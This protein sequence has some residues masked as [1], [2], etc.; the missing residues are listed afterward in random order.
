MVS[1]I[2]VDAVFHPLVY[3]STGDYY[4]RDAERRR[5]ARTQHRLFEV[6]LDSWFQPRK[7]AALPRRVSQ[8]LRALGRDF[9][10]ICSLLDETLSLGTL[11]AIDSPSGNWR[12]AFRYLSTLQSVFLN[13][14][15]GAL[16]RALP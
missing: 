1:H 8:P 12:T 5:L 7:T 16:I 2:A 6:Y 3:Y 9:T 4:D 14:P 11:C 10:G 13:A 15:A